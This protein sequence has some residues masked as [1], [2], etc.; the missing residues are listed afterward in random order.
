MQI[1]WNPQGWYEYGYRSGSSRA[2]WFHRFSTHCLNHYRRCLPG[3]SDAEII[4]RLRESNRRR[5]AA[6]PERTKY[7]ETVGL[8]DLIRAEWR[9]IRDGAGLSED[10]WEV[11]C[12]KNFLYQREIRNLSLQPS[13]GRCTY[14]YFPQSESGP[15]LAFNLDSS[16]KEPFGAP[17]WPG[18]NEH[19]FFGTVSSGVFLDET[20]PEIFPVPIARLMG[21]FCGNTKEAVELLSRY[22]LFWG[23]C[24]ALLVDDQ[25]N[26]AMLEKSACRIGVRYSED[27][28]GYITSMTAEAPEF[29]AFLDDRR[30]VSLERRGLDK[31]CTDVR[32]WAEADHRRKLIGRLLEEA[33][34]NPTFETLRSIMQHR[35]SLGRVCYNG[36]DLGGG[37]KVEHTLRTA[38]W[39]LKKRTAIWWGRSGDTPSF[40]T[41]PRSVTY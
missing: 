3:L 41:K 26:V 5:L 19:L 40:E 10:L 17:D 8:A 35:S 32:F 27:G 18:L 6:E 30:N 33:K 24:N 21:R 16:P 20:S 31:N 25:H 39:N 34:A 28:Y 23:P 7:P 13:P 37:L 29:R 1:S 38:I 15:L 2:D 36:D 14:V 11:Y 9:G 22:C 12:D 4:T